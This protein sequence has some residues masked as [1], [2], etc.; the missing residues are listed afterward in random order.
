MLFQTSID[1][2]SLVKADLAKVHALA[3]DLAA[4]HGSGASNQPTGLYNLTGVNSHAAGGA[5]DF[6]DIINAQT[7]VAKDNGAIGRLGWATTPG[8]AGKLM[9]TLV[10]SAAGARHDL[11][12]HVRG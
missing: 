12:W 3:I 7:E 1:V 8:M 9:Q 4:L 11:D 6:A 10:A 2:D 5:P